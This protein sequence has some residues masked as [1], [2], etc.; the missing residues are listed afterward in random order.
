[1][2]YLFLY[3]ALIR[4]RLSSSQEECLRLF[5]DPKIDDWYAVDEV[6][7]L[8]LRFPF[9]SR[10]LVNESW[11]RDSVHDDWRTGMVSL[12]DAAV[13][14]PNSELASDKSS[15]RIFRSP[16]LPG[17]N[18]LCA[19]REHHVY[20]Q[21]SIDTFSQNFDLISNGLLHNLD[22][23]NLF[24]AGG[25]VIGALLSPQFAGPHTNEWISSDI[26]IYIYGLSPNDANVK[27]THIFDVFRSNLPP[28]MRT[29]AIRNSKTITFYAD[30]PL[31]RIQV[32]LK[33][34]KNPKDVLLNFD[35][36]ICAMGWDGSNVWMLPRAAR[37]LESKDCSCTCSRSAGGT[38]R[39][40]AGCNTFTMSLIY[41]HYLSERRASQP[42]R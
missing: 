14:F 20:I 5:S 28:A 37:A 35:L 16:T 30:Y 19:D 2:S 7:L 11:L 31:R 34:V 3:R 36:D 23:R 39:E 42:H 6:G 41:G 12:Q 33:L 10:I 26:D 17:Y 22:W 9:N 1:M 40:T 8:T 21:P 24:V 32:V 27:I 13:I 29:L 15:R 38:N 18:I 4:S 25:I